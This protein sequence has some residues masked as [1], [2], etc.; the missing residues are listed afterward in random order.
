[1]LFRS[2]TAR[3]DAQ[4]EIRQTLGRL[5]QGILALKPDYRVAYLL[6]IPGPG[7]SRGDIETFPIYGIA[8]IEQIGAAVGL[9]ER[10][11]A[12]LWEDLDLA[13]AQRT[14]AVELRGSAEKFAFLW[15]YLPIADLLI[16]KL[17]GLQQQQIINRRMLACNELRT[18][19]S[20][21]GHGKSAR[22]G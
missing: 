19:L 14:S 18:H 15:G 7:K 10:Q 13:A 11:F 20:R 16:G 21:P 8:T 1:M 4:V 6:N 22:H 5:W 3:P 2:A 12:V 9:N 17:L